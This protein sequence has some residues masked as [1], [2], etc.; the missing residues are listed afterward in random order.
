VPPILA[1]GSLPPGFPWTTIDGRSFWDGGIISN[2]PLDLV[3][4]HCGAASKR[5]FIVD[6]FAGRKPLPKNLGEVLMRRDEILYAER[7]RNDAKSRDLIEDQ[8]TPAQAPQDRPGQP[9]EN[10][11]D[12]ERGEARV[13]TGGASFDHFMQMSQGQAALRQGPVHCIEAKRK[14]GLLRP[15]MG[16]HPLQ[17]AAQLGNSGGR[18]GQGHPQ[19]L[20]KNESLNSARM[21]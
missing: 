4:D 11:G 3:V 10:A 1:S 19:D 5:V 15:A 9:S 14:N 13:F 6:L 18:A 20:P 8:I 2:S 12:E 21:Y 16:F 17:P 7:I